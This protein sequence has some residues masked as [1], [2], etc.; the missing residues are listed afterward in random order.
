MPSV[1]ISAIKERMHKNLYL[2]GEECPKVRSR[3]DQLQE[4]TSSRPERLENRSSMYKVK[5]LLQNCL[6]VNAQKALDASIY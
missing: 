5:N 4:R 1:F 3:E 6:N 2:H